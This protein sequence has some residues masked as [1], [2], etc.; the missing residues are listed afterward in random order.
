M[1]PKHL[2]VLLLF[3]VLTMTISDAT[4]QF[5]IGA[6]VGFPLG[7]FNTI[8]NPGYG[9]SFR[10]EDDWQSQLN[11]TASLGFLSFSGKDYSGGSYGATFLVPFSVGAK[12]YFTEANKGFYGGADMGF[13][14]VTYTATGPIVGTV[15]NTSMRF[16]L[17]PTVGYRMS[18]LDFAARF[19]LEDGFNYYALRVAYVLKSN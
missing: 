1:K 3:A 16:Q 15:T 2:P 9:L 4:A 6:D 13:S 18:S 12:Y 8:A 5:S 11:W 19:T 14:F 10:Y 17:A 7:D